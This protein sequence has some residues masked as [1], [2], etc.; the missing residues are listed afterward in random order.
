MVKVFEV[1]TSTSL[2]IQSTT[3]WEHPAKYYGVRILPKIEKPK[4]YQHLEHTAGE[5]GNSSAVM[6]EGLPHAD[7]PNLIPVELPLGL[8]TTRSS[9]PLCGTACELGPST[10]TSAGGLCCAWARKPSRG[11]PEG[12]EA[13]ALSSAPLHGLAHG[14]RAPDEV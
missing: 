3:G 14:S 1:T 13:L 8:C 5:L 11:L 7:E 6:G 2:F 10:S 12:V 9:S 4:W